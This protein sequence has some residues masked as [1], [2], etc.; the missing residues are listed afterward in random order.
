MQIDR[1]KYL[2]FLE[3]YLHSCGFEIKPDGQMRCP[4]NVYHK[5]GDNNFSARFYRNDTTTGHPRI[6]CF[7][8]DFKGD[9]YDVVGYV[10]NEKEFNE[11]YKYLES[12]YG[13]VDVPILPAD[14]MK[15]NNP[16]KEKINPVSLSIDEAKKIYTDENINRVRSFSKNELNKNGIIKGRWEYSDI[17]NNIIA[18]DIRVENELTEPGKKP[19][20]NV[21]T[22][23][24][25]GKSLKMSDGPFLVYNLYNSIHGTGKD[26]PILIHEGAKKAK[27]ANNVFNKIESIAY[28]RGT[29]NVDKPDWSHYI[30]RQI[31]ILPDNDEPGIQAAFKLKKIFPQSIILKSIFIKYE[32]DN[33]KGADIEQLLEKT[34]PE[35]LEN[36]ILNYSE[37][38]FEQEAEHKKPICLGI[39]D[40]GHLFFIDRFQR[41]FDIK[42]NKVGKENLMVISDLD[43]WQMKYSNDK[44]IIK[45]DSA[46]NDI[47]DHSSHHEFDL[48]KVRGRG[49][50]R[51]GNNFI[52]HDGKNTF[53]NVSGEY[54]YVRKNKRDI[55]INDQPIEEDKIKKLRELCNDISFA[56]ISDLI[57]LLS[58][59]LISPFCGAL[60][61]R[62]G[63]LMT[64]E[65]GSGKT[66]ILEK[67][68]IPISGGKH[69]NTH[70]SSPAGI[71]AEVQNDSC[72]ILLEE[73]EA[74]QNTNDQDKNFNRN[75]F[76]SMMR[77]SSS[78][79]APE[80]IK[81]NSDQQVVKYSMKNMF[82]F[83]SITPTIAEIADDNRI[84]KVNFTTKTQNTNKRKWEE[85]EKEL[86]SLL[87][88]NNCRRIRA[89][90]WKKFPKIISDLDLIIDIMKYEYGKSSRLADGESILIS[91]Y[92]NIFKG[93]E[94]TRENVINFL[95]KYYQEVGEEE[96]RDETNE[97]LKK[98][99]DE[100][101]EISIDKDRKKMS[102]KECIDCLKNNNFETL[103]PDFSFYDNAGKVESEK[104]R[105]SRL[106]EK[107]L[108][109]ILSHYGLSFQRDNTLAIANSNDKLKKILNRE[110]G[111]A[112]IFY[113]HKNFI[114]QP[115]GKND[116][117]CRINN[118]IQRAVIIDIHKNEK[119]Y[120]QD[121]EDIPF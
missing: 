113:R 95:K 50:W 94:F 43:Y 80:G 44:G 37:E 29:N 40:N 83:V 109:R 81:S 25:N 55:G 36:Y 57:R 12:L 63:L 99:F 7:V 78:D 45:W 105:I 70:Y 46:T 60:K 56:K 88:Y 23:W 10:R 121:I 106:A 91:T 34:I 71:R 115:D 100:I 119:E 64:G 14:N 13:N 30:N 48:S 87:N 112:K 20:K 85:I 86:T 39:D 62:P 114:I 41:L 6:E 102:I 73:A 27:I 96:E 118:Q 5:H 24:Y 35:E 16:E 103:Y 110:N 9:I 51:E 52:Y 117:V 93:S 53:G 107:E 1:N 90:I 68:V 79:N 66:T 67:I 72:A 19:S 8:C 54:M 17:D 42:R 38:I 47:L 33:I 28:N 4:N 104:T 111:Y 97:L 49:A 116:K 82:L 32:L 18:C 98:I 21:L 31:Y 65:S 69:V 108:R 26:K 15:R 120:N 74:N 3:Q 92:L 2:P 101:I 11:Q 77:A 61:F 75:A 58:W 22:F 89:Y 59:S 76:F 84:F